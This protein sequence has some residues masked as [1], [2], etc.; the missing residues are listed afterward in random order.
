MSDSTPIILFVYLWSL[1]LTDTAM[2]QIINL[3]R[4]KYLSIF[5]LLFSSITIMAQ[6]EPVIK[7]L[8]SGHGTKFHIEFVEFLDVAEV[9]DYLFQLLSLNKDH[10][11]KSI[12]S[13]VDGDNSLH[14]RYGHYFKGV[15]V[16]GSEW[17]LH[18]QSGRIYSANGD[19]YSNVTGEQ[20]VS[21]EVAREKA[22]TVSGA[23]S[24]KWDF[25]AEEGMLKLWKEDSNATYFPKG[26]MAYCP[27]D[28]N[29]LLEH[30]L[31]H[32]FE[33]NSEEPLLRKNFYINASTNELWAAEDL[34][35]IADVQG[36]ANTK[37]RGNQTITT[38]STAPGNYRL[39]ETGRGGG[40]ET[41]DMN[42][43]TN[44][45]AAV[46]FVD[47]NNFWNNYNTN[48]DEVGGD[49]HFGAEMTYDYLNDR[50]NRNS[51]DGN[52]A[53]IRSYVHYRSNYSNA[54]WNGSVMTYGDG[55]GTSFTPLTSLDVCGHEIAHAITSNSANL[56]YSYESGA[57]NESFS[58]IFGNAI[59][60]YADSTQFNWRIGEDIMVSGNGIRNMANPNTHGDPDTYLG[61]SWYGGTG[62]NGG[63]HTNSG[64]QNFW[65]YLLSVGGTGTNDNSETYS[66]DSLGIYKAEQIAYRNLTVYLTRNSDYSD[67]RYYG[68]QAAEDLYGSCGDE[69]ITTTNAWHAVGVG[70]VYDSS[71]VTADFE[72]DTL[73][74]SPSETVQ[75]LNRSINGMTFVWDFGDGTTSSLRNPSHNFSQ[76]GPHTIELI[77][78]GCFFSLYDTLIK[79]NYIQFDSLRDICN[80]FL[81]PKGDWDTVHA[82][83]G[84]IY[85]HN[86]E[87][88]YEGNS[89]DTLTVDFSTSDSAHLTFLEFQY[90]NNYDSIYVYDGFNTSGTLLGGF[91]GSNLPNGGNPFTLTSGAITI[92]HFSD[93]ALA[94]SG[95]K[96]EFTTFRPAISLAITPDTTVCYNSNVTLRAQG[97]GGHI[98]DYSYY[99]NGVL[100]G[101][102][103]ILTLQKD[104]TIYFQ[105]GDECMKQYISDSI[106]ITVLDSLK[107]TA[108]QDLTLCFLETVSLSASATGGKTADYVFNWL[109]FDTLI[110]PWI[111]QFTRDTTIRVTVTD[112]CTVQTDT[113]SF[114]ITV[115]DSIAFT[116]SNDSALCQGNSMNIAV[117]PSGGLGT[118]SYSY[119]D[120]SSSGPST[121]SSKSVTPINAGIHTYWIA[122]TD[123]C[124]ETNDTAFYSITMGDSL[125]VDLG[126]DTT[127]CN[128]NS[129]TLQADASGGNS[130]Y[131]YDWGAGNVASNT[132]TV[133]PKTTATYNVR[134][135]DG[136]SMYEPT[137][138]IVVSV[139]DSLAVF[140]SGVDTSCY[141]ELVQF[142]ANPSGGVSADYTYNWNSGAGA[143]STYQ[144]T[145]ANSTIISVTL[146]DGCTGKDVSASHPL[147]VREELKVTLPTD[148]SICFGEST[149]LNANATGGD[150][151]NYLISWDQGLGTGNPKIVSPSIQ[152][153]YTVT[154]SDNCSMDVADSVSIGVNPLPVIDFEIAPNPTCTNEQISFSDKSDA[155][156]SGDFEWNFG[157]G[158]SSTNQNATHAYGNAGS[159]DVSFKAINSFGCADSLTKN[160]AIEIKERPVANYSIAWEAANYLD[161]S[162]DF[163]NQSTD[164][165]RFIW[166]FGDGISSTEENPSYSY[167]DTGYYYVTLVAFSDEECADTLIQRVRVKDAFVLYVPNAYSPNSDLLNDDWGV[168]YRGIDLYSIVIANMWGEILFMSNNPAERWDGLANGKK[169]KTT[170]LVYRIEGRDIEGNKFERSGPIYVLP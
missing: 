127:I 139:L 157:D 57:L 82:C 47:S 86:G 98:G 90:E 87:S 108:M 103:L 150:I 77:A 96:A 51:F 160:S 102:T 131:L 85:D 99:W 111:A 69:V 20:G 37:Y 94:G 11:F 17:I 124:T 159:Y 163:T 129:I 55:N 79:V 14:T 134:L 75:F 62:D 1:Y 167:A 89:R 125:Q 137:D 133:S 44:Y 162:F 161:P 148:Y 168:V 136:C 9:K 53:K 140:I 8:E 80:G 32:V 153:L 16:L 84:F 123:N 18:S 70:P 34:L 29:F 120:G 115:R 130:N 118:Y 65:F 31:C 156:N 13:I 106:V 59:E 56:I 169:I 122:F 88:D 117:D 92:T 116:Q 25:P 142:T 170:S 132:H 112:G 109:P 27:K 48:S 4:F 146:S 78:E 165:S 30:Q 6:N 2:R 35:H 154:V 49:A 143:A 128:Q 52:G 73:Y 104:T 147:F 23:L 135:S 141:G 15:E 7:R 166:Y 64:V 164:A 39:R 91:T 97:S 5:F 83:T 114:K 58:D 36:V 138:D 43:G 110:N 24:F 60:F 152:T 40:I 81:L 28:F 22:K 41:F 12:N 149:T 46:D 68:I 119:S 72:A 155:G 113:T 66:V 95:F 121:S 33:I 101:P 151:A 74:C 145:F 100:G 107:L 10:S 63:V 42:E 71:A 93:P 158:L 45:G 54:F 105:F 19:I 50:F 76:T 144:N 67:A 3:P 26:R 126:N 38:D 61:T 21:N